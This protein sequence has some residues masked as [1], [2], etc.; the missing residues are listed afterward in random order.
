[1]DQR[2]NSK[3]GSFATLHNKCVLYKQPL[4]ELKF[5]TSVTRGAGWRQ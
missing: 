5:Q 1:M 4:L 2:F 3:L